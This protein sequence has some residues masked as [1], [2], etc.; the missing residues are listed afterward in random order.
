MKNLATIPAW[1]LLTFC[2]CKSGKEPAAEPTAAAKTLEQPTVAAAPAPAPTPAAAPVAPVA[3]AAETGPNLHGLKV[4][5]TA[6]DV[7][8]LQQKDDKWIALRDCDSCEDGNYVYGDVDAPQMT[9]VVKN[10]KVAAIKTPSEI[11]VHEEPVGAL[12]LGSTKSLIGQV[13][14]KPTS[15]TPIELEGATGLYYTKWEF[16]KQG[17]TLDLTAP[18]KTGELKIA[19]IYMTAPSEHKTKRGIGIG[20]TRA[21]VEKAYADVKTDEVIEDGRFIAGSS[22]EGVDF[23]FHDDK[24]SAISVGV[25]G[26]E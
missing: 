4:G 19:S 16:A 7:E 2:A 13:L 5:S 20:S 11:P 8:A 6:A 21:E 17:I 9:I 12:K 14:G 26:G 1:L 3:M 23:Y 15:K 22:N 18:T 24:V 10:G 25:H